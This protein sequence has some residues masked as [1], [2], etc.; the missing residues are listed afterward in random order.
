MLLDFFNEII[1]LGL[2]WL[3]S[4]KNTVLYDERTASWKQMVGRG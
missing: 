2:K 4:L 3:K 1:C